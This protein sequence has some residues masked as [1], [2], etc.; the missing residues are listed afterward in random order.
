MGLGLWWTGEL[1][2]CRAS[3]DHVSLAARVDTS[4]KPSTRAPTL[5]PD[6]W[7]WKQILK[8]LIFLT[9]LC[10]FARGKMAKLRW[11]NGWHW[12]LAFF[13]NIQ[14]NQATCLKNVV[15]FPPLNVDQC[16]D[17]VFVYRSPSSLWDGQ[18]GGRHH[19]V[20][21]G[22]TDKFK[23]T[24]NLSLSNW[25][26]YSENSLGWRL[27]C[28]LKK[29]F[30]CLPKREPLCRTEDA[31]MH[32]LKEEQ[33]T[34]DERWR[35]PASHSLSKGFLLG[36]KLGAGVANAKSGWMRSRKSICGSF[37]PRL[38]CKIQKV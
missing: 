29:S 34:G 1:T 31:L 27:I 13:L 3:F 10:H 16:G 4:P 35:L 25:L 22:H 18:S 6:T 23:T 9:K 5:A 12:F 8:L 19:C 38:V 15:G 30:P 14:A 36:V 7:L 17:E 37:H 11:C 2:I 28:C 32:F 33:L 20:I 26:W 21:V 24:Q